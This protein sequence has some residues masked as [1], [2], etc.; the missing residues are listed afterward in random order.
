MHQFPVLSGKSAPRSAL[1]RQVCVGCETQTAT[2]RS[3]DMAISGNMANI[4]LIFLFLFGLSDFCES[5]GNL[6]V[7]GLVVSAKIRGV[8]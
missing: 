4:V 7:V 3:V 5:Q 2:L 6:Q 1:I 8:L